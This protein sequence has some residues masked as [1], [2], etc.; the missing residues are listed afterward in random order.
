VPRVVIDPGVLVA[1][2]LTPAGT[3]AALLRALLA[4]RLQVI[5]SPQL[6]EELAGVLARPTFR[7]YVSVEEAAAYVEAIAHRVELHPDPDE[8]AQA[9]RDPGDDYLV[10][11]ALAAKAEVLISG[12][13]D[14]LEA[15]LAVPVLTPRRLLDQLTDPS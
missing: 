5:A 4:G 14:L 3:P 6:L 12:D 2:L 15:D 9:T 13:A 1:A 11:L 10:A 8:P 7:R